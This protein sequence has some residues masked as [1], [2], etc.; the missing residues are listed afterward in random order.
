M[1]PISQRGHPRLVLV[2]GHYAQ[3][4]AGYQFSLAL[5]AG[6]Q[7][8][9]W[10]EDRS[11]QLGPGRQPTRPLEPDPHSPDATLVRVPGQWAQVAAGSSHVLALTPDGHLF[12]WGSNLRGELGPNAP[13][14]DAP[15]P[16]PVPVPG[17]YRQVAAG[18]NFSLALTPEGQLYAWG[19]N[20]YGQLATPANSWQATHQ[21]KPP[22]MPTPRLIPGRWASVAAGAA[23]V[24]A[25][26][27]DGQ[28][29]A[30][31]GN[32]KGQLGRSPNADSPVPAPLPGRYVRMSASG[33]NCLALGPDGQLYAWGDNGTGQLGNGTKQSYFNDEPHPVP[34]ATP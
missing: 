34:T 16:R 27:A 29:W 7:L 18:I 3:L 12:A 15:H 19:D 23:F 25:L 30:W 6:G 17:R 22:A 11:G 26:R 33:E 10:G 32:A 2:P 24:L 13:V 9:A 5:T 8:Y 4:A 1:S 21:Q 31:G 14:D 20:L 28:L